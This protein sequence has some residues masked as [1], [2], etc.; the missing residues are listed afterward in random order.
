[1]LRSRKDEV[2]GRFRTTL[3]GWI[4]QTPAHRNHGERVAT[5]Y[6]SMSHMEGALLYRN[7]TKTSR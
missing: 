6:L 1:M 5:F 3:A 4:L 2:L 7:K